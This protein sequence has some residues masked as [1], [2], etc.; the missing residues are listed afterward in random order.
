[1]KKD[2]HD[3]FERIKRKKCIFYK[4]KENFS[5]VFYYFIVVRRAPIF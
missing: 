1:M 4:K 3:L 5:F 2:D